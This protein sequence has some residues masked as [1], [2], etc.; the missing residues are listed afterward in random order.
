LDDFPCPF[1]GASFRPPFYGWQK[2]TTRDCNAPR[3]LVGM[4]YTEPSCIFSTH[5]GET[6]LGLNFKP[7]KWEFSVDLVFPDPIKVFQ[8]QYLQFGASSEIVCAPSGMDRAF[9]TS[10]WRP[11]G[12]QAPIGG[13]AAPPPRRGGLPRYRPR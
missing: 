5:Y 12:C 10:F 8:A 7:H 2:S 9:S 1:R 13:G 3:G 6:L 4:A 11:H